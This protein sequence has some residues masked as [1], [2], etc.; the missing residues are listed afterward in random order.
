M[1]I[2]CASVFV[3]HVYYYSLCVKNVHVI[4]VAACIHSLEWWQIIGDIMKKIILFNV[5]INALMI[6]F[7]KIFLLLYIMTC[8][9]DGI[10][11]ALNKQDYEHI[12][13]DKIMNRVELIKYLKENNTFVNNVRW[14]GKEISE[15][16]NKENYQ[17]V[18]DYDINKIHGG[19]DCSTCD[20]FLLLIAE[21]FH[22]TIE[23]RYNN[24]ILI[25]KNTTQSR[26]TL[27]FRSNRGHFW[28]SK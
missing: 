14:N 3:S 2:V 22:V 24:T 17:A 21:L 23:H 9:W 26:K 7:L 25:Y 16:E 19:H 5:T 4:T 15:K 1:K 27:Y 28:K 8:F 13:C 11:H 20:Y 12:S 10:I 18:S 6:I